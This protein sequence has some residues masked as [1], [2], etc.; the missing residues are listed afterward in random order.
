MSFVPW[1]S[2]RSEAAGFVWKSLACDQ[3]LPA[4]PSRFPQGL[5]SAS[6]VD[7]CGLS[8]PRPHPQGTIF[9]FSCSLQPSWCLLRAESSQQGHLR[10]AGSTILFYRWGSRA[11][12]RSQRGVKGRTWTSGLRI[13]RPV[14][15]SQHPASPS[16]LSPPAPA[17]STPL[18]RGEPSQAHTP[19][20][21][22]PQHQKPTG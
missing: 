9:S 15:W 21:S 7:T 3:P 17:P 4:A 12:E 6:S 8:D 1:K 2:G 13:S 10:V 18:A 14:G 11:S 20:L 22:S 16:S 5:L 19:L